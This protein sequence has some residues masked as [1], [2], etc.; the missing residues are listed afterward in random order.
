M[1]PISVKGISAKSVT[2]MDMDT[3]RVLYSYNQNES[4][5]IASISNIMTT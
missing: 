4:R 1:F 5:L 3:K 2:V